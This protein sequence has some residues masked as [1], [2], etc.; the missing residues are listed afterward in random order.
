MPVL[1]SGFLVIAVW[2]YVLFVSR[3][4]VLYDLPL[5]QPLKNFM[6]GRVT[7]THSMVIGLALLAIAI[8]ILT[9]FRVREQSMVVGSKKMLCIFVVLSIIAAAMLILKVAKIEVPLIE[10]YLA[11]LR[12]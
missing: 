4:R 7:I 1:I 11:R 10:A 3:W 6:Q 2:L 5:T 8:S 9:M 12:S